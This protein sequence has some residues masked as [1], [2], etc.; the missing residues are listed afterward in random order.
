MA[1]LAMQTNT[2]K[3]FVNSIV[4]KASHA[5]ENVSNARSTPSDNAL[6]EQLTMLSNQSADQNIALTT[7]VKHLEGS[8][9]ELENKFVEQTAKQST[10]TKTLQPAVMVLAANNVPEESTAQSTRSSKQVNEI[11]TAAIMT[12]SF[13]EN[14]LVKNEQQKRIKQQAILRALSQKMELAALSGLSN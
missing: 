10:N 1:Y 6:L 7:R 9:A 11:S 12:T 2:V 13:D 4:V 14:D 3:S 8:V 5:D